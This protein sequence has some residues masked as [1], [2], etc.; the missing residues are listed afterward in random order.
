MASQRALEIS[1]VAGHPP[2]LVRDHFSSPRVVMKGSDFHPKG[3]NIQTFMD[4]SNIGLGAHL[5]QDSVKGL[6]SDGE[7]RLHINVL[8][9]KAVFLSLKRFKGQCQNE[10]V[11]VATDNSTVVANI[12]KQGGTH[13]AEI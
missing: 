8:E 12:N 3:H 13:S 7:K 10:T 4:T 2:T 6:W 1:L 9:L 5:K 11:L